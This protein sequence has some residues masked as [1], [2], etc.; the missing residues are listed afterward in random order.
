M[1]HIKTNQSRGK[2][3]CLPNFCSRINVPYF[4]WSGMLAFI[5]EAILVLIL[6][7]ML[8]EVIP[9]DGIVIVVLLLITVT[10]FTVLWFWTSFNCAPVY[11]MTKCEEEAIL[12]R[13]GSNREYYWHLVWDARHKNDQGHI[14]VTLKGALFSLLLL[15]LFIGFSGGPGLGVFDRLESAQPTLDQFRYYVMA[16]MYIVLVI[17]SIGIAFNLYLLE[18]HT[19]F[20]VRHFS[21]THNAKE[22]KSDVDEAE[23]AS[24]S[25][26]T[27]SN[28]GGFHNR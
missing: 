12:V 3:V 14:Q 11:E 2:G 25:L 17:A 21:A 16:K 7:L 6:S 8:F 18:T 28:K 22:K 24:S 20:T 26:F 5:W 9:Q 27:L 19:D 4:G 1:N 15:A 13:P 10:V 23:F